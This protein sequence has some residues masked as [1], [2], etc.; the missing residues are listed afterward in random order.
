MHE[1]FVW[2]RRRWKI[3][4]KPSDFNCGFGWKLRRLF[5]QW[6]GIYV[7][8]LNMLC[9]IHY[10]FK[11]AFAFEFE[12]EFD[13]VNDQDVMIMFLWQRG[14]WRFRHCANTQRFSQGKGKDSCWRRCWFN[15]FWNNSKQARR[16]GDKSFPLQFSR[17]CTSILSVLIKFLFDRNT[18]A[19]VELLEEEGI[20]TPAWFSF[21]C[22][23]ENNVA[24]GDSILDCASIADS[25]RQVVAVGVNCTA[26]RFIHG[27]ISSI[28]KVCILYI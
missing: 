1:G 2:F 3:W 15:C 5:G 7:S 22:K 16:T 9:K 19:Y 10:Q 12:F 18:Q 8:Q 28:K 23:D 27:L 26:P 13:E 25:C 20:E 24:S 11:P 17:S 6:L 14:L 4:K 21:S